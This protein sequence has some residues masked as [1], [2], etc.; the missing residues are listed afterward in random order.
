MPPELMGVAKQHVQS[1]HSTGR[2]KVRRLPLPNLPPFPPPP[3]PPPAPHPQFCPNP[4]P[5]TPA[6]TFD[7]LDGRLQVQLRQRHTGQLKGP[8]GLPRQLAL[9]QRGEGEWGRG[10][11]ERGGG[12][13]GEGRGVAAGMLC[14]LCAPMWVRGLRQQVGEGETGEAWR[15]AGP[16]TVGCGW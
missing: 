8:V 16:T 1:A 3:P 6:N 5:R 2:A 15:R 10:D 7:G 4:R 12:G 11:R 13:G 9:L 14:A